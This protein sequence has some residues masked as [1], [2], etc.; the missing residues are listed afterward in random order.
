MPTAKW[1]AAPLLVPK[2]GSKA[3]LR[4]AVDLRPVNAAAIKESWPMPHLES[5]NLD[6]TNSTCF[7]VLDFVSTYWQL[8]L[9]Q[10]SYTACGVVT[11]RGVVASIW[12]L[13]GL[14]NATA[15]FQSSMEPLFSELREN[16]KAWIDDFNLFCGNEEQLLQLLERV[17]EIYHQHGLLLSARKCFL[18][19]PELKWSGRIIDKQG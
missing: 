7:A 13:S 18:F 14:A 10:D 15:H 12:V 8:P 6:F 11:P 17:F 5:E 2:P 3:K 19:A 1:Q 4:M 16:M 9:H